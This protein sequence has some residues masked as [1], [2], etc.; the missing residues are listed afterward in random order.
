MNDRFEPAERN[1]HHAAWDERLQDWLDADLDAAQTA[2]VESHLAAC[3]VCRER[4]AELREIDAAL[5]DALPRLA[6]DEAF[7][8]RLLAQ[9][10]EQ[11]SAARAEAR[12]RAEEEFAAGATALARGWRRSLVLVVTGA[13]AGAALASALLG[14]L[15]AS[16]LTEALLTH[17]PGALDQGWYQLA[18]TML[19]GGGIGAMIARWLA[20][21]AE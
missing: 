7:D 10:H 20:T 5:A 11:D 3:P 17:A 18:S 6:L 2:L 1:E 8:R 9:I 16:V 15:E 19:L 13:I 12:R 4:L 14:Q 21:A